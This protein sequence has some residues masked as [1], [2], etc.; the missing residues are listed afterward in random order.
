MGGPPDA[1]ELLGRAEDSLAALATAVAV[2]SDA[3]HRPRTKSGSTEE[4]AATAND[5]LCDLALT[6]GQL[7][8]LTNATLAAAQRL[9]GDYATQSAQMTHL[10]LANTH[11]QKEAAAR[12]LL[13]AMVS[14]AVF[15][16]RRRWKLGYPKQQA[17]LVG[18][19]ICH[20]T[21]VLSIAPGLAQYIIG[22]AHHIALQTMR[23]FHGVRAMQSDRNGSL[24][25]A[26]HEAQDAA[27]WAVAFQS[28]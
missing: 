14:C 8:A 24:V 19:K 1:E 3:L 16:R 10:Q 18:V 7:R 9:E 23:P 2:L 13:S 27:E 25:V 28:E 15:R 17:C 11:L 4:V 5:A 20:I 6:L 12:L 26:F 21:D 22:N